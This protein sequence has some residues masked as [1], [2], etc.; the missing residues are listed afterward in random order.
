[1]MSPPLAAIFD[2]PASAPAFDT[3]GKPI[4]EEGTEENPVL[5][6]GLSVQ[7]FDD[8]LSYFFKS[9]VHTLSSRKW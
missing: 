7:V 9:Y 3:N 8:L 6:T 1:M 4:P 5:L 2:I